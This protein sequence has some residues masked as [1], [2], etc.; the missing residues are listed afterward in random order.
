[1]YLT[2]RPLKQGD[3]NDCFAILRD[4]FVY[5]AADR[6]PLL[7][8]WRDLVTEKT[9]PS[10]V[11]EDREKPRGKQIVAFGLCLFVTDSFLK[12]AKSAL[13]PYVARH[14]FQQEKKSRR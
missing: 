6:A 7:S 2:F 5:Q 13:L 8:L 10:M 3:L 4:R 1:M 11:V 9:T 14:V 12:E